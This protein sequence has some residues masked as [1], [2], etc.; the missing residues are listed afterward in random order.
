MEGR[1]LEEAEL[2]ERAKRGDADAYSLLVQQHQ[3]LVVRA[4]YLIVRDAAEAEDVAQ[5]AFVRAY[6][7]LQ[8]F[9]SGAPF[10]PWLLKVATNE[11]LN[12]RK[13]AERHSARAERAARVRPSGD[14]APSPEAAALQAEQRGALERALDGLRQPERL[15]IIYR[16]VLEI[17]EAETA[18]ILGCP[19]GTVKS[20]LSRGLQQLRLRLTADPALDR[21]PDHG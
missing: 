2:V 7:A 14:A 12:R 11:A 4:V 8:R 20:R 16:Y 21:G 17:S 3:E 1:P 9:R 18:A 15:A 6:L 10:R 19:P 5:E 13:A